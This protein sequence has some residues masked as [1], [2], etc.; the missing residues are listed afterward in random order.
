MVYK[1]PTN[2]CTRMINTNNLR[3]FLVYG[4]S[5]IKGSYPDG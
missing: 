3:K 2:V 4:N 5:L 1:H